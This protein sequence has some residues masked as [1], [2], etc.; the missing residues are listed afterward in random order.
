LDKKGMTNKKFL[1]I[2]LV[3][4]NRKAHL[5]E[6]FSQIFSDNSPIKDLPITILDNKSTDGSS[7]LIEKYKSKYPNIKHIIHN[8]NIGGNGNIARAFELATAKYVWVLC[9]DDYFN[10]DNWPEVEK[11]MYNDNDIIFLCTELIFDRTSISQL[12]HQATLIPACIYKTERITDTILQNIINTTHTMFGQVSLS[13]DI[14]VNNP[15]KSFICTKDI[16]ER[17]VH[18]EENPETTIRGSKKQDVHPIMQNVFWHVG[19][20]NAIQIIK[21]KKLRYKIIEEVN[22]NDR[23]DESFLDYLFFI[24]KYNK[25]HRNSSLYNILLLYSIFNLKQRIYLL[26]AV[27]IFYTIYIYKEENWLKISLLSMFKTK[28]WNIYWFRFYKCEKGITLQVFDKIKLR[29]IPFKTLV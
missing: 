15:G 14:L 24:L 7:E 27:L 22:F 9:D 17:G 28:I 3:T 8:K 21:D 4:Y 26:I 19:F 16:V 6:T 12:L 23:N 20:I 1:E 5:Q 2:I 13:A 11:A 18:N 10:W 25:R 29:I